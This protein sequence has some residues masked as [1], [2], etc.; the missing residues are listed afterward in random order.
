MY[1]SDP[2]ANWNYSAAT[3][4]QANGNAANQFSYLACV[5]RL[6]SA[7]AQGMVT[8]S[9][10]INAKVDIGI[11]TTSGGSAQLVQFANVPSSNY[12]ATNATYSGTPGIGHH[13]IKWLEFG[14]GSGT[15]IWLGTSAGQVSGIIGEVSN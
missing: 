12:V 1:A 10:T 9:T 15:Q 13:D 3:M 14:F 4:R 11:D 8:C 7:F 5:P 2:A 6:I